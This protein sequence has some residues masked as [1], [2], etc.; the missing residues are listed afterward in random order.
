MSL[1]T[2]KALREQRAN[3]AAQSQAIIDTASTEQRNLTTEE[4]QTFD[5]YHSEMESLRGQYERIERQETVNAEL[6]ESRGRA[7]GGREQPT[8]EVES[9]ERPDSRPGARGAMDRANALRAWFMRGSNQRVSSD[10]AESAHRNGV[11]LGNRLLEFNMNPRPLRALDAESV[12]EWE[13]R[14]Q[15]TGTD[16]EGGFTVPNDTMRALE[17]AMLRFGGMRQV[18][19]IIR[20]DTGSDLP[21]PTTND[22]SNEGA[23]LAENAQVAQADLVFGQL[24]LQAYKYSSKMILIPV[25]LLQDSAVNVAEVIGSALGERIGRITNRHFTVG[26]GSGQPNGIVTAATLG[27]TGASGQTATVEYTDLVELQHSVDPDYRINAKW[28]FADSTLKAIK[29][30]LD[31]NDRPLWLPGIAVREPDTI[32]GHPFVVNQNVAA[33]A[34]SAKSILFGDLSKYKIRDVRQVTLLRLDERFADYH[35]VAF[36]AFSRHDGDLLDAGTH[37]VKYYANAAS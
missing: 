2:A 29:Q 26:T 25:E 12:R 23:I 3:L 13:T 27:A 10:L 5:R 24:V 34:A 21:W 15:S 20:T 36:L 17:V 1:V 11:D 30:L 4:E 31:G 7:A 18:G 22:T 37:P 6:A 35:Q 28:M 14:A 19:D 9:R 16:T 33:M 8:A 32:L